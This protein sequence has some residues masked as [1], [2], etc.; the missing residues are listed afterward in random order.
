MALI[1]I[2]SRFNFYQQIR[3]LLRK[4]RDGR[5]ND[6]QLLDQKL[7]ISATLSLDAP[8]GQVAELRQ[9]NPG[10][11]VQVTAWHHGLTGAL[12]ALPTV[13]TEWL[14]GRQHRYSD[15]S[16][17]AF[18]DIFDHRLYCLDYLAW[19]KHQLCALAES[20]DLPP[21]QNAIL[22]LSGLLNEQPA[23]ALAQYAALFACSARSM[24]NLECW[25]SNVFNVDARIIP[26]TGSWRSVPEQ[27]C[28]QLGH[29]G[30]T[31]QS[32]PMIGRVRL[33][34][35]S[36]F[37]VVLGPMSPETAHRFMPPADNWQTAWSCIRDYV[38][39]VI[40]FTISL[41]I[42]S[43]ELKL[44]PLGVGALGLDLCVGHNNTSHLHQ[45]RLP[46]PNVISGCPV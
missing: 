46:A 42:S 16:A 25:L 43:A 22:S 23:P 24:V 12:G 34:A 2:V 45:V 15:Y 38:G 40:D 1:P 27:E 35:H 11:P 5:T 14:I 17:K 19:Q 31:L 3:L 20:V 30:K 26:F 8:H 33:E 36:H 37:D 21:L 6:A 18:L 13:Y 10:D 9:D 4:L 44:R 28:C 32:A 41:T 39:P 7:R 29:R